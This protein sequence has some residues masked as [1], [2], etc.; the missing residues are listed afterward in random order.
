MRCAVTLGDSRH[1]DML[2][3]RSGRSSSSLIP[4]TFHKTAIFGFRIKKSKDRKLPELPNTRK[5]AVK[6]GVPD[7]YISIEDTGPFLR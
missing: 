4:N 7:V 2:L 1:S 3:P 6:L 5:E